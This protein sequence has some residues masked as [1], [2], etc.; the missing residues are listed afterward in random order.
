MPDGLTGPTEAEA[1]AKLNRPCCLCSY[2]DAS[3]E[4]EHEGFHYFC[5][6]HDP[7]PAMRHEVDR[8]REIDRASRIAALAAVP[9][10][11]ETPLNVGP[12]FAG[13][14]TLKAGLSIRRADG[15]VEGPNETLP[16]N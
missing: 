7:T 10:D 4:C 13:R 3:V 1:V 8:L 11:G 16:R 5:E 12:V 9:E 2:A 15:T 14:A 6:P